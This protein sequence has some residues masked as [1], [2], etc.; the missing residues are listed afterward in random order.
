M[1]LWLRNRNIW[2]KK[3]WTSETIRKG[4]ILLVSFRSDKIRFDRFLL[5]IILLIRIRTS[6]NWYPIKPWNRSRAIIIHTISRRINKRICNGIISDNYYHVKP[7]IRKQ[8][9]PVKRNFETICKQFG[10]RNNESRFIQKNER[11]ARRKKERKKK[12]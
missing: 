11:L 4:K 8:K 10:K 12:K 1:I 3:G 2:S 7:F 6:F 5:E 9:R